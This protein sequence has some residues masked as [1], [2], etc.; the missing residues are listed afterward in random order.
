MIVMER[1]FDVRLIDKN[2]LARYME[3]RG[4]TVRELAKM[5]D[6]SPATIG[7]LRS[8]ARS[9]CKQERARSIE[10]CL[11]APPGSLFVGELST[12]SRE[13]G[14]KASAA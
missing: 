10:K 5:V 13:R 1:R 8:G 3:F 12:V 14:H 6:C 4:L 7:H 9:Y 2:S 11:Q